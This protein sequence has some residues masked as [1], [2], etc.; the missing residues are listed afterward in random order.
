[1]RRYF[2]LFSTLLFLHACSSYIPVYQLEVQQGP[3][4]EQ[5]QINKLVPGM[6]KKQAQFVM[7][8][9]TITDNFHPDRWDYIYTLDK[10]GKRVKTKKLTLFFDQNLLTRIQGDYRPGLKEEK[11]TKNKEIIV[12]PPSQREEKVGFWQRF[13][14]II[15]FGT[16]GY[17][18]TE[19]D[20]L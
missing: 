9:P 3:I 18:E 1:M 13:L 10:N 11:S 16:L 17:Y 15:S 19:Y 7:G 6:T 12:V 5:S 4:L 14:R 2:Y 20:D 8:T